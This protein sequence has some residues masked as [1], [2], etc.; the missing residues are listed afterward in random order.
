MAEPEGSLLSPSCVPDSM[1]SLARHLVIPTLKTD[2][3][4]E[5]IFRPS[6]NRKRLS[7]APTLTLTLTLESEEGRERGEGGKGKRKHKDTRRRQRREEERQKEE[8]EKRGNGGS[9]SN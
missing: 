4:R 6:G 7:S 9:E 5:G 3:H 2:F 8:G 1:G